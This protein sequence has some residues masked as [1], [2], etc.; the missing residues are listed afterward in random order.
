MKTTWKRIKN[1]LTLPWR[2]LTW[3]FLKLQE[4]ISYEPDDV[5]LPDAVADTIRQ[6]SVLLEHLND[7]R[8]HLFRAFLALA[9]TTVFSFMFATRIVDWLAVPIGGIKALRAIEVTESIAAFMRVSL[10]SG[11]TLAFPI[12]IFELFM[13]INPGLTRR[14]RVFLLLAAPAA[15][16][17]FLSGMAFAY[18]IMLPSALPFLLTFMGIETVPRPSNYIHFVTGLL[19]W[20]GISFQFPLI[21]FALANIGLVKAHTLVR[22]WRFAVIGIAVLAAVV[23]PTID[24]VN[25]ALVMAP[26]IVLYFFSILL[27]VIAQKNHARNARHDSDHGNNKKPPAV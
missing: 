23:T 18:F 22:G 3:P 13:F 15:G 25:M 14:E 11:L 10:L 27:A 1:I 20:I 24:P 8:K 6:P 17:L 2:L 16:I 26:M 7:L 12:I 9:A 21:I 19:F 5:P 4:F